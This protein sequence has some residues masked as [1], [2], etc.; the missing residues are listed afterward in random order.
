MLAAL[1]DQ[2]GRNHNGVVTREDL[3]KEIRRAA[4]LNGD[5]VVTWEEMLA[6]LR[7]E[8][9]FSKRSDGK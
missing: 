2:A 4:D 6:A 3:T 9:L 1:L 5:G 8:L 7:S